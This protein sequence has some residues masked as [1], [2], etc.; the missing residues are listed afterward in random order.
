MELYVTTLNGFQPLAIIT[1][2]STLDNAGVLDLIFI[3]DSLP[4][5]NCILIKLKPMFFSNRNQS[6]KLNSKK[7]YWL[8]WEGNKLFQIDKQ[9]CQKLTKLIQMK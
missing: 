3:I 1:K 4:L 9:K 6:I 7:D 5:Q 2:T 8:L